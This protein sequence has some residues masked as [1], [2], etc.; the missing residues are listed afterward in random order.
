M[1]QFPETLTIERT[2]PDEFGLIGH[3]EYEESSVLAGQYRRIIIEWFPTVAAAQT[4][5]DERHPGVSCEVLEHGTSPSRAVVPIW[6]PADFDPADAGEVWSAED[7][8]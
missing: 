8:N 2:S 6:P 7:Y 4:A 1:S 5:V 3:G